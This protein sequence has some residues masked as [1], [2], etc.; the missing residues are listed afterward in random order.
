MERLDAARLI[1]WSQQQDPTT[2]SDAHEPGKKK[3]LEMQRF[4][5]NA[6][7]QALFVVRKLAMPK[8]SLRRY[9]YDTTSLDSH[10]TYPV[11]D[12]KLNRLHIRVA[13]RIISAFTERHFDEWYGIA[14]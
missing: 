13:I 8:F 3:L 10:V 14:A 5:R 9:L 6:I 12:R 4:R 7:A 11:A 1:A 2:W